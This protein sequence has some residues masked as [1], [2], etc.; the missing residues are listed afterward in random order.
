MDGG[1]E[2]V[3]LLE[4]EEVHPTEVVEETSNIKTAI[5]PVM[6]KILATINRTMEINNHILSNIRVT[7]NTQSRSSTSR[8]NNSNL[9]RDL[10]SIL[11][12]VACKLRPILNLKFLNTG[13][14]VD[15][16]L[17]ITNRLTETRAMPIHHQENV[18]ET[19]LSATQIEA[20]P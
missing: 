5:I 6:D 16:L 19:K 13:S 14:T 10:M 12:L 8:L 4:V 20:I 11:H 1:V 2:G 15:S 18:H 3:V 17:D 7:S 9:H